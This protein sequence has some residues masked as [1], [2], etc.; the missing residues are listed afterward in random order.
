VLGVGFFRVFDTKIINHES[1]RDVACVV[2]PQ[3]RGDWGRGITV[4]GK[5]RSEAV[6]RNLTGL[7]K[8]VHAAANLNVDIVMVDERGKGIFSHDG[9]WDDGNG[10]PHVFI[11]IHGSVQVKILEIAS[12]EAGIRSGDDAVEEKFDGGEVG[13]LGADVAGIINSIATNGET[14]AARVIL[15]G[16]EGSNNAQVGR[17]F[18]FWNGGIWKEEHG[19]GTG[20][21]FRAVPLAEATKFIFAGFNPKGALAA[22]AQFKEVSNATGVWID[23][24]A[25]ES[26][27]FNVRREGREEG[28]GR[29][30]GGGA[31]TGV[32]TCAMGMSFCWARTGLG[33]GSTGKAAAAASDDAG[34]VVVRSDYRWGGGGRALDQGRWVAQ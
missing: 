27:M 10:D 11:L 4:R 19:F 2:F 32:G 22:G 7:R 31:V 16:A 30:D 26:K 28:G 25:V 17:F 1:E 14:D 6:I 34:T 29:S 23:C 20:F 3:A 33:C 24:V 5:E 21:H 15:F 9:L 13:G 18:V 8:A 12:H